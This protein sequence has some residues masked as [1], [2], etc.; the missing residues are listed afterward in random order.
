[1]RNAIILGDTP[2]IFQC[3]PEIKM[4]EIPVENPGSSLPTKARMSKSRAKVTIYVEHSHGAVMHFIKR[5][6]HNE[7]SRT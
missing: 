1:M 4:T 6:V 3:D 5:H 2:W 7:T